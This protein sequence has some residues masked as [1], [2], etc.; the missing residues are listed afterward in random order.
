MYVT[1][2]EGFFMVISAVSPINQ[3]N[4]QK[5]HIS[6]TPKQ[7]TAFKG[8]EK[9][10]SLTAKK[11]GVGL[12]A[13]VQTGLGQLINGQVGK[14][15]GLFGLS[16]ANVLIG[17]LIASKAKNFLILTFVASLGIKIYGI[18][19]AVKNVRPDQQIRNK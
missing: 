10:R 5:Y 13:F 3:T 16:L 15:F 8:E 7:T 6:E 19:D 9:E 17:G 1:Y 4:S 2:K 18:V 11:W 14:A 12:A